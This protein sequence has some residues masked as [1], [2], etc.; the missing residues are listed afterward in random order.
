MIVSKDINPIRDTYY[1]GAKIIEVIENSDVENHDFIS[2]YEVLKY[3]EKISFSLFALT[4]DWLYIIGAIDKPTN[5]K[6]IKCF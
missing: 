5:G 6:I 3:R 4:L 1:L 2:I